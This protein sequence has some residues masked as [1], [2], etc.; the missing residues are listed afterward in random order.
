MGQIPAQ[1][2]RPVASRVALDLPNWAM[3]SESH[4][5]IVMAIEM[6]RDGGTFI[7]H[8]PTFCLTNHSQIK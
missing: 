7:H 2:R 5:H 6:A 1:W 8:C 4:R 3:R